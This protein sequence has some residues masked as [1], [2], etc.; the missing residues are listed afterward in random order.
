MT[1]ILVIEDET[2]IRQ[3]I[4]ELLDAE[5]FEAIAA[6]NGLLGLHL[7][8]EH[9]PDLILCDVMMPEIDGYGVLTALK[10]E[11]HTASIPFIFLTAKA[12]RFDVRI[13]MEMGADDYLTKPCL[14]DELLRA[15]AARLEKRQ[16]LQQRYSDE[17]KQASSKLDNLPY[18][19]SLTE[20]PNRIAL[21]ERFGEFVSA[22]GEG[23]LLPVLCLGLDRF[24]RINESLG[25]DFGDTLLKAVAARIAASAGSAIAI[26]RLNAD[27]FALIAAPV[28]QKKS[29][30]DFA[31][32]L[33]DKLAEPF[34]KNGQE[35]FITAS[36]GIAF[37]PRDGLSIAPLLQNADKAMDRAKQLGGNRWEFYTPA[38]NIGSS[39]RAALETDLRYALEREELSVYYQPQVNL[40]TGKVV[41]CEALLRWRHPERGFI[42]PAKFI[43]LAEETGAIE[44]IGEW[45]L[46]MACQQTKAWHEAG[47]G[48]LRVAVNLSGR[49]FSL[50]NLCQRIVQILI[51]T[52]FE[53]KFLDLEL[54]ESSLIQ[55]AASA[56]RRLNALR[57][58]GVQIAIDDFGTGYAGFNYL[59][60]FTF[61]KLKIDRIFVSNVTKDEKNKAITSSVIQLA[62]QMKVKTVAEGVETPEE[63]DFL[64]RQKC[65]E[66]QG[67]L[68]SPP[69]PA[70]EFEKI[71]ASGKQLPIER[72]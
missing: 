4:L 64:R 6:E 28:E 24:S 51:E 11:T 60:K 43:P 31:Q 56:A 32:T 62:S 34:V 53:P 29:A 2:S 8:A 39:D 69:L 44:A 57:A 23:Q 17:I 35:V 25:Y 9:Q 58:I 45:V 14:P 66:M 18:C 72:H 49:Q 16:A 40:L 52:H 68:F 30:S 13:G 5:G 41:G 10:A 3:N 59:Q 67:Y 70:A 61:D 7:A 15:I 26:A 71:L 36:I 54:T 50:L 37:Y 33:S 22:A 38:F 63:L 27:R 55:D 19:D 46:K 65:D 21:Q 12:D 47:F 1:K 48:L 42:S 20:L